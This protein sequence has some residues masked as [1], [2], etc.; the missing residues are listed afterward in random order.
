LGICDFKH[1]PFKHEKQK[2]HEVKMKVKVIYKN[3]VF[4]PLE[5][6]NIDEGEEIEINIC[7]AV[8]ETRGIIRINPKLGKEIAESD[9]LSALES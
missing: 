5:K 6:L 4:R 7:N 3:N 2:Y 9:E 1:Q 8:H